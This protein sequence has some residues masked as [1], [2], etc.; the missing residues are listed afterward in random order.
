MATTSGISSS[1]TGTLSSAGIGSGLD[2]NS[3]VSQLVAAERTPADTRL[4]NQDATLTAEVS[5]VASLKGALASL[6]GAAAGMT[7]TSS[8]DLRTATVG[9]SSFLSA[10]ATSDAVAGHYDVEVVQLATAG[11]I[12]STGFPT[13]GG[14]ADTT[15]GTGT[16]AINVG[17][18][19]LKVAIDSQHSTLAQIRD[20]INNAADNPGVTATLITDQNGAHLVL[21]GNNTGLANAVS[22]NTTDSVDADG[23]TGDGSGL[24][25]LFGMAAQDPVKD[26]AKDAIVKVGGFEIHNDTNTIDGAIQGVKMVLLKANATGETTSLDVARD[27]AGIESKAQGLVSVF[28]NLAAKITSLSSYNAATKSGAPLLGDSLLIGIDSQLR[29]ILSTP[30]AGISGNYTTLASVGITTN[31][32]GTLSL[33]SAKF[34]TALNAD[35]QAVNQIFASSDGIASQLNTYL[36]D[37]LSST[38]N[39]AARNTSLAA[40]QQDLQD[41]RDALDARMQ[42]LQDRYLQQF[43]ALDTLLSQMQSTSTYLTQQLQGLSNLA[44]YATSNRGR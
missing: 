21:T 41:Q 4:T 7:G 17:S 31:A 37:Q 43:T 38:G 8:F 24:S 9:D 27:N 42:V 20:A 22:V 33:D 12:S 26:V 30:V 35:P 34:Q 28:N 14:G 16:L 2:V 23:N 6:Q 15:I 11:R 5:A 29:R 10:S 39:I 32:D 44:N 13:A 25:Q 3:L 1:V 36:T 19:E 40:Q 18:A